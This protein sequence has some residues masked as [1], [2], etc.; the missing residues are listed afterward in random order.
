MDA[1]RRRT[2]P[3]NPGGSRVRIKVVTPDTPDFNIEPYGGTTPPAEFT[4][5]GHKVEILPPDTAHLIG[6][7]WQIRIDCVIRGNY[8]FSSARMAAEEAK[9]LIDTG[10]FP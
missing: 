3:P 4:Y 9:K 2:V 6:N 10:L 5:N 7:Y 8:V 1:E